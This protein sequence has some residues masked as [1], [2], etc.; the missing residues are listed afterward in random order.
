MGGMSLN[1]LCDVEH[2]KSHRPSRP[3][4]SGSVSPHG[5]LFLAV[6][7]FVIGSVLLLSTAYREGFYAAILLIAVIIWYDFSHK[8]NPFSV[9]LMAFCRFLVFAVTS[10]ATTGAFAMSTMIAAGI[11]FSYVV[12]I[13]LVA[14]YENSRPAPFSFPVI[15]WMLAGIS[16]LDGIIL[17]VLVKP[18]WLLVGLAGAAV[19]R[20]GQKVVRGD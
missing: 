13:S 4:P 10:L 5:A 8:H 6:L 14:R 15:P 7:F 11:Q 12:C 9:L 17:A 20:E 18:G 3:I 1:D 19:M 2:D 16:L